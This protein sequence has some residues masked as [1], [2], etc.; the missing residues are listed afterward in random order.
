MCNLEGHVYK[1]FA[2]H[3]GLP[4]QASAVTQQAGYGA[5]TCCG[6]LAGCLL[7]DAAGKPMFA[8]STADILA[9]PW[10]NSSTHCA[11]ES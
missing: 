1:C 11:M 5:N 4:Q 6:H 8:E 9:L 2:L 3:V 10:A 7:C